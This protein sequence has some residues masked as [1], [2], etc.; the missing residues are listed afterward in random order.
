MPTRIQYHRAT[1]PV[2]TVARAPPAVLRKLINPPTRMYGRGPPRAS[3]PY[4]WTRGPARG[5]TML[6]SDSRLTRV[7]KP[8]AV[9]HEVW[10]SMPYWSASH[11]TM[12]Q[13][14][15]IEFIRGNIRV[16][17]PNLASSDLFNRSIPTDHRHTR[18]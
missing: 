5:K 12:E 9:L 2:G 4:S 15:A 16:T 14:D 6:R 3:I 1:L 8:L 7:R 10:A 11:T 18:G 13:C 17:A